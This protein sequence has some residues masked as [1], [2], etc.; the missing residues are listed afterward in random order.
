M[1]QHYPT[2]LTH[3]VL[4]LVQ[5]PT[6]ST[7]ALGLLSSL[8]PYSFNASPLTNENISDVPIGAIPLLSVT[9]PLFY[10]AINKFIAEANAVFHSFVKSDDGTGFSGQVAIVGDSMGS[11]LVYEALCRQ[12]GSEDDEKLNDLEIDASKL[13]KAPSPRRRR[14]SSSSDTR[15]SKLDFEVGD[16][17]MFG[18]PLSLVLAARKLC[19]PKESEY[20][21]YY[22]FVS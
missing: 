14:S 9:S 17:F 13:L 20:W 12:K 18:S 16:F 7:D 3:V 4:K 19:N 22:S 21:Y 11:L 6:V 1:R 15:A 10:E 2:L 5:C 8:S